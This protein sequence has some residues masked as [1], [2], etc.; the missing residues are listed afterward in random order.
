MAKAGVK[1]VNIGIES[2][3]NKIIKNAGRI[4]FDLSEAE[5]E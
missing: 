5:K 2:S 4:T 1:S 3:Q